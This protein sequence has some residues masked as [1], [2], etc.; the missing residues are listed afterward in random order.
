MS[1]KKLNYRTEMLQQTSRHEYELNISY[2][3][4]LK[5]TLAIRSSFGLSKYQ[6]PKNTLFSINVNNAYVATWNI[7][8]STFN[9]RTHA[10]HVH[11][12][13]RI[14]KSFNKNLGVVV[15]FNKKNYFVGI[16]MYLIL[17]FV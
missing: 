7:K 6:T 15:S 16:A 13:Y 2:P 3:Y 14:V 9:P 10:L 4:D 1:K 11:H 12:T 8:Y 17:C 5:E